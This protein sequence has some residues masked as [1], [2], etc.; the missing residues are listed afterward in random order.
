MELYPLLILAVGIAV[1]LTLILGFRIN[2]FIAL[3]TAAI[4]ISLMAPGAW[5]EKITRV[6]ASFGSVA[7]AI[8]IVIA[9]AAVI[10]RALMDSGAAQRIVQALLRLLGEERTPVALMG[11]GFVLSVPVFFDT[12]FYLLIPL[13]RSLWTKTRRHYVL[14]ITAMVAGGAVTHALVPP[15][16]GPLFM[17]NELGID[18]GLMILVGAMIG[19]PVSAVGLFVC[20]QLDRWLDIPM[21]PYAGTE[22]AVH[23]E[24]SARAEASPAA[25]PALAPAPASSTTAAVADVPDQQLPPLWLS[26]APVILPVL[27]ISA[28]TFAIA[29][30][31]AEVAADSAWA[32]VQAFTAVAGDPN[33]ALL[34]SAVIA[35]LTLALWKKRPLARL[36]DDVE[37]ALMSGGL[38]ILITAAGG[39]F[40]GMLRAAGIQD[41]MQYLVGD[42]STIS[43]VA[44]LLTAF[45]VASLIKFAQGSST[46]AMI[47]TSSMFAAMGFTATSLGFHPVYLA[48][49]IG[50]GAMV[51][52]WMNNSG[53]WIFSKMSVLT[54]EETLKSWTVLLTALGFTGLIVTLLAAMLLPLV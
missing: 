26:L 46:V 38:I 32:R 18:L 5:G 34:L 16:P 20:Y 45:G 10:G 1:V 37:E 53:F 23:A 36:A 11:S 27:L 44:V 30:G 41:S 12:V 9:L 8:G 17:A 35:L 48:T 31:G 33:L 24:E 7:G 43:G 28:N 19:L 21:R 54:T 29:L 3:I 47:T 40:G 49:V 25:D 52:D 6:A 15:T 39:A 13:A 22:E 42:V 2:A 50:S 14:Y 51:G 4:V